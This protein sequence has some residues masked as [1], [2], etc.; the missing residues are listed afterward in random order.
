[1][2]KRRNRRS[3]RYFTNQI[4][5]TSTDDCIIL[6]DKPPVVI[7]LVDTDDEGDNILKRKL[8]LQ[9]KNEQS[10]KHKRTRLSNS[11]KAGP[12]TSSQNKN[13]QTENV[14]FFIDTKKEDAPILQIPLYKPN[15]DSIICLDDTLPQPPLPVLNASIPKYESVL[16]DSVIVLLDDSH[17][18][19]KKGNATLEDGELPPDDS[20]IPLESGSAVSYL[21]FFF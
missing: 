9:D 5:N 15:N 20:F 6:P 19:N 13:G 18:E 10:P 21:K 3:G 16:Q 12:S 2:Y 17:V 8:P 7:S 14:P 4:S 1:M 11:P